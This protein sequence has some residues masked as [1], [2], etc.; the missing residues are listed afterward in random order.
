MP[1]RESSLFN[2]L[3]VV[4]PTYNRAE[5]L[6]KVLE[7][8]LAQSSPALIHELIVVDD[9]STDDTESMVGHFIRRSPFPIR[10]F[11]QP[12]S[13]PAAARNLGIRE[14][15]SSVVLFTDSDIIP[16]R[17]LV[18]QHLEWHQ[19]NPALTAAVLGHVDWSQEIQT[20]PFMRWFGE[21]KVF[22]FDRVRKMGDVTFHF[23]Y[24]CN[25]SLKTEFLGTCGQFDEDFKCAA[26]ED[27]E[28]GFRLHKQGLKLLYNPAAIGYHHQF[29]SFEDACRKTLANASWNHVFLGKEAGQELRRE[30]EQRQSRLWFRVAKT[31]GLEV[32]KM[33]PP[34]KRLLDS[35]LPLPNFV[36]DLFFRASTVAGK[37]ENGTVASNC[38]AKQ[39]NSY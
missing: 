21:E 33:I 16:E 31:I 1:I 2:S 11:R 26:Y 37:P 15:R 32:S 10:Y 8:Y 17:D 4:I 22:A 14:S 18:R 29:F 3:T 35:S 28:L 12:N 9:G 20:T 5:V 39:K 34:P 23:F 13:G 7:A 25:V 30:I 24:T 36:Y 38:D 6:A 19:S 27:I